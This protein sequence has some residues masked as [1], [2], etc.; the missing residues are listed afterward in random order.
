MSKSKCKYCSDGIVLNEDC[1]KVI[2]R[3][4]CEIDSY[5]PDIDAIGIATDTRRNRLAWAQM[6]YE[7]VK[8]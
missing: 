4:F 5:D 7:E 8:E 6:P 2:R 1:T 3:W